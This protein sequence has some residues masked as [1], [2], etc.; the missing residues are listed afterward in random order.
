M[1]FNSIRDVERYL[2]GLGCSREQINRHLKGLTLCRQRKEQYSA[3][4][5]QSVAGIGSEFLKT[6]PT[7]HPCRH[8]LTNTSLRPDTG[9][10]GGPGE[11]L[12]SV[13][14]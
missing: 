5:V 12:R 8:R 4:H 11:W 1:V 9:L 14:W 6:H 13:V 3:L 7:P 10:L 2:I